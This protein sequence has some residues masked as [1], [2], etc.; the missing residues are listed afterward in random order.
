MISL[1]EWKEEE[2]R[3]E[4]PVLLLKNLN[5][6]AKKINNPYQALDLEQYFAKDRF[7]MLS[8]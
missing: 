7:D 3:D 2:T 1:R 8:L 6:L 4:N 5:Q